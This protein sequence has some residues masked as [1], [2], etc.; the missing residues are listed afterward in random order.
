MTL[1]IT[2]GKKKGLDAAADSRGVTLRGEIVTTVSH[3]QSQQVDASR[4]LLRSVQENH[5]GKHVG[6]YSI[7]SA[8]R[9]VLEAGMAQAG[10]D[11]SLLCIESSANQVNQFGGYTGQ[12]PAAFA[13]FVKEVAKAEGFPQEQ[14]LLGGD[15]LGPHVWRAEKASSAMV[16]AQDLVQ[17]CVRAGYMKIHLDASMPCADDPG[18]RHRPLADELV[19]ARAAELCKAAEEAHKGLKT[20]SPA[21]LYV[22]GTEVPIPGGEQQGWEAPGVTSTEDLARTLAMARQAFFSRGLQEAW[23]RVIAVVV[24]PGVEF[25][26]SSVFAYDPA[27]AKRLALYASKKWNR[28]YEAHSTDYQTRGALHDMVRDHF[29]ILKVGPWLTFAFREAVFALAEMEEEWLRSRRDVRLS[30]VRESL[31]A[32]M[33]VNPSDWKGYYRGEEAEL[34]F[35]RKYSYSD[36]S[37]YYW[38]QPGVAAALQ[39]LL[40]NLT[41][42]PAPESLVSQ[43]LPK[44]CEAI[45]EG[46]L[47]NQ[48]RELIRGKI[49]EVLDIY[50]YACGMGTSAKDGPATLRLG[51]AHAQ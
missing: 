8:N 32:A 2:A 4:Q 42:H 35:A 37:R 43:Y 10:R 23:E 17:S 46:R 19:S 36:R 31:E 47:E 30:K 25:G 51:K 45:R 5:G 7:C 49:L 12:T 28:A 29:A 24:Q 34:K 1:R 21:P 3:P 15:H 26:D 38:P 40:N 22:I 39:R 13:A 20:G 44:Q 27:K 48:P 50:A 14:I 18:D 6:I 11:A 16:K 9:F 33:L 41:A